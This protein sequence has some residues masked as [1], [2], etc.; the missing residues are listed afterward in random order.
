MKGGPDQTANF[1]H[2]DMTAITTE[3]ATTA[4]VIAIQDSAV[5]PVRK[6][7]AQLYATIVVNAQLMEYVNVSRD[8]QDTHV[9]KS[10]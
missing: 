2:V 4:N 9:N 7:N 6:H 10:T 8:T 3:Y 1:S 5:S